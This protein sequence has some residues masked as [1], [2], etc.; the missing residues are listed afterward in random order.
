MFKSSVEDNALT[1][2]LPHE[3]KRQYAYP[4]QYALR[5]YTRSQQMHAVMEQCVEEKK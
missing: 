1:W 3:L 5:S 2:T 4:L